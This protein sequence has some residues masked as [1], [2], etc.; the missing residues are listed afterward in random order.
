MDL[1]EER[2]PDGLM[3]C[4]GPSRRVCVTELGRANNRCILGSLVLI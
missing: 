4:L 2:N 3:R 1:N